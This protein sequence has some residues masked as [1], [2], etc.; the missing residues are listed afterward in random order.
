LIVLCVL[1][2]VKIFVFSRVISFPLV[3]IWQSDAHR[4]SP[5]TTYSPTLTPLVVDGTLYG[6]QGNEVVALDA[7]TGR[8]FWTFTYK[9]R[10]SGTRM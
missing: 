10:L 3:S 7:A 5:K 8:S 1:A 6:V 4:T 9:V 2:F